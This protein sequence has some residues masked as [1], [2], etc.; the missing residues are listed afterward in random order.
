MNGIVYKHVKGNKWNSERKTLHAFSHAE[1][2]CSK[3][4]EYWREMFGSDEGDKRR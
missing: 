3:I 1:S 4:Y 2:V